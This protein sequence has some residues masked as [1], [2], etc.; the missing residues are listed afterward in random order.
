MRR[1][2]SGTF[3][4][5]LSIL[6][7]TSLTGSAAAQTYN[8][9]E[10]MVVPKASASLA[11]AAKKEKSNAFTRYWPVQ[12][13]SLT[14]LLVG[15]RARGKTKHGEPHDAGVA[16]YA[17]IGSGLAFLSL[18][19]LM[20]MAFSP[21]QDGLKE[22]RRTKAK[23]KTAALARERAAEE[24][25]YDAGKLAS[26]MALLSFM[27]HG[28]L[29]AAIAGG[30]GDLDDQYLL[31]SA[32]LGAILSMTPLFFDSHPETVMDRHD[33][34]KKRIYGPVTSLGVF[35]SPTTKKTGPMV[36]WT[37]HL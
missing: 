36:T 16:G 23:S 37:Y 21:Y 20:G 25:L 32:G 8:Y 5:L 28:L 30:A 4:F 3:T 35:R 9:P 24:V 1:N 27:T 22:I 19:G 11:K 34:Y 10:L 7:T 2:T 33:N 12:L 26:N 17:A 18:T 14:T 6:L 15:L 29:T 13:A 31:I